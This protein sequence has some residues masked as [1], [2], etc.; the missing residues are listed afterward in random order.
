MRKRWLVLVALV[1]L[2]LGACSGKD[3]N[4]SSEAI[5]DS[6]EEKVT[7]NGF[8][9]KAPAATTDWADMEF[10]DELAENVNTEIKW[11][12]ATPQTQQEQINLMFASDD[13]PDFFYSAWTLGANDIVKYGSNGQLI[14]LEDL[15]E[16]NAPNIKTFFEKRPEIEKMITAPDGHIYALPLYVE[17]LWSTSNDAMFVNKKWL[18]EVGMDIPE[19]TDE[20]KEMLTAFK[21]KDLNDNGKKDEIPFSFTYSNEI[22]GPHSLSGSF[23]VVGRKLGVENG[24]V[25][26]A[27]VRP[28]YKEYVKWMHEL[29]KEGLID[30]EAFTHDINVYDSKIKSA[31]PVLGAYFAWSKFSSFGTLDKDYVAIPPLKGPDGEQMW[32]RSSGSLSL[33]G[34]SITSANEN[35]ARSM[36]W[37][38]QMFDPEIAVQVYAG[39]FGVNLEKD[40]EKIVK[41]EVPEGTS[42]EEFR[43]QQSPGSYG[44]YAI[45]QETFEKFELD[46]GEKEKMEYAEMYEPYQPEEI[47]PDLLYS[48]EDAERLSIL[49]TDI[50]GYI[51]ETIPKFIIEGDVD[52]KWDNYIEQLEKMGLDELIDIHQKYYD[53]FKE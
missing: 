11:T 20:F 10:L 50:D 34:F 27:P 8:G 40:G 4:S 1:L 39:P 16:E 30:P 5:E 29:Y 12:N 24:E 13:L 32:N 19:T 22:R 9:V 45:L 33:S 46:T 26:L 38:D 3:K 47:Y 18:D 41:S 42:Y 43:H 53:S 31:T 15:I 51:D 25:Y 49:T 14:A 48:A 37:V 36:K 44:V 17:D 28:E 2:I 35:P 21:D 23:G 7:L 52:S 6:G